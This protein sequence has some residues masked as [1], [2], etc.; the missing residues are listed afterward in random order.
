[1]SQVLCDKLKGNWSMCT[2]NNA[3][4]CQKTFK[5]CEFQPEG[6]MQV[7][8]INISESNVP[9]GFL[10]VRPS[11]HGSQKPRKG[12]PSNFI[13]SKILSYCTSQIGFKMMQKKGASE[14]ISVFVFSRLVEFSAHRQQTFLKSR[15]LCVSVWAWR[16]PTVQV[17]TE[18]EGKDR[19]SRLAPCI[20]KEPELISDF[21]KLKPSWRIESRLHS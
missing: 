11:L 21:P 8:F 20:L 9:L 17:A 3:P 13:D 10:I 6:Y 12:R 14:C 7:A 16:L 2:I 19:Y 4:R 18:G 5:V 1:M 15:F